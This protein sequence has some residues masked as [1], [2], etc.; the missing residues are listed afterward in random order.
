MPQ[1]TKFNA[2]KIDEF[3]TSMGWTYTDRFGNKHYT[4]E[5]LRWLAQQAIAAFGYITM[6][7]FE[8]GNTLTLPNH[9]L[10]LESTGE[11]Y[12]WDGSFPK[13]VPAGSTP[14]T[15]GGIGEGAWVAVGAAAF[16]QSIAI[17]DSVKALMSVSDKAANNLRHVTGYVPGTTFGGGDFYWD[18]SKPKSQHNGITIFSPTVPW[19]GSYSGLAAFLAGTGET[20]SSG[21]GCWLRSKKGDILASWAGFDVTGTQV[22]D[23]IIKAACVLAANTRRC[24]RI[25]PGSTVKWGFTH[26]TQ[27]HDK[28][29]LNLQTS[30]VLSGISGLSIYA[31]NDVE[32]NTDHPTYRERTVFGVINGK[33]NTIAGFNWNSNFTDYSISPSDTMHKIQEH[34]KGVVSEGNDGLIVRNNR[35]NACHVFVMADNTNLAT[36]LQNKNVQVL[37][38]NFKYVV[39][40]CV[41]SRSLEWLTFDRND[42]SYQGRTWHT[43]GEAVAP[44][45]QTKHIRVCD[46]RFTNQI[47]GQSCITPGPHIESG[48][49]SGNYCKRHYGLFIENGSTSNLIITNNVSISTGER[50]DTAHILLVGEVDDQPVGNSPHSNVLISNN[51]FQGG[52]EAVREYNTGIVLRSGF[53]VINNQMVDCKPPAISNQSFIGLEFV[54]NFLVAPSDFPDLILG[55]QHTVIKDNTLVG[56]RIRARNLGYTILDMSVVD[57]TF[58][59]NAIGDSYVALIDFTE[60]TGLVARGNDVSAS[61][62]TNVIVLPANCNVAG[63]RNVGVTEGLSDN[64]FTLY[65]S[66]LRCQLGDIVYNKEPSSFQNKLC[67]TCVDSTAKTFGSINV[68]I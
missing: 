66:K 15:T 47:A 34:W 61:N 58:R 26:L 54:G 45:T 43:F 65:G 8:D 41:I 7:S 62:F 60:F 16:G 63:F 18:A 39:N 13:V 20:D 46:N 4:I 30:V 27:Y 53:R 68:A 29:N 32:F 51:L 44:T 10:R 19:D 37:E 50:A 64:P 55:G 14:A 11:Y 5:G 40:Y 1:D 12:R 22:A 42:V 21:A 56:V 38:N 24:L 48:L 36:N 2:G 9:A 31:D 49:I 17:V 25:D 28:F 33:N 59:A 3:V 57:N 52:G 23:D 67:W 35:V 6:D